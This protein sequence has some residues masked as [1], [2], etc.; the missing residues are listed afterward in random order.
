MSRWPDARVEAV[1]DGR[2]G[3]A[4][5]LLERAGPLALRRSDGGE[6]G[7]AARVV[8][9]G[10]M[11]APVGGDRYGL[12]VGVGPGASLVVTSAAATVSLPGVDGA[13]SAYEL[14]L[15]VAAGASLDWYPEPVIAAAGSSLRLTTR[16]ELAA[17]ARLRFREEQVFGRHH[18][19]VRGAAPGR[20]VSRLTVRQAGRLILDQETDLGP[21]GLASPAQLGPYR[22]VG[23]LLAVGWPVRAP[24]DSA[25][26]E[27][28][29]MEPA[30]EGVRLVS[31]VA[32]DG[33]RLRR[34]LVAAESTGTAA[35]EAAG[36]A[37]GT[38]AEEEVERVVVSA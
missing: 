16:I 6:V 36:T 26:G 3:T 14:T 27:A 2:G 22:A 34:L 37:A 10:A 31:A 7:A 9:V 23:Q 29:V 18:D 24:E 28:V 30:G 8:V 38:A 17:G 13:E 20:L 21:G 5:A 11:A 1:R 33:L 19:W 25:E 32:G 35:G 4:L 15:R 12:E